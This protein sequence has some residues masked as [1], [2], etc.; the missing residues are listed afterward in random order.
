MTWPTEVVDLERYGL[1]RKTHTPV[2]VRASSSPPR[3]PAS[4]PAD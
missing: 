4:K 2:D 3:P 1:T